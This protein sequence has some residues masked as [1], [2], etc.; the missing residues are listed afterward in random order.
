[1]SKLE[2]LSSN[3]AWDG[4]LTKFKTQSS[5]LGGLDVQFN[6]FVPSAASGSPKFPVLYYLAGLTCNE[7]TGAQKGGFLRDAAKH[8]TS[9]SI[10]STID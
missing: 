10:L 3:K 5:A 8:G 2:T 4:T 9:A 6:V 7:D 1:M